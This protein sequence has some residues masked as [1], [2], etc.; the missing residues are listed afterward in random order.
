MSPPTKDPKPDLHGMEVLACRT[1]T[2]ALLV[3][4]HRIRESITPQRST[5][6]VVLMVVCRHRLS[7]SE[8]IRVALALILTAVSSTMMDKKIFLISVRVRIDGYKGTHFYI[9]NKQ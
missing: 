1:S 8:F 6:N 5:G 4:G 7:I 3:I 2:L 9:I